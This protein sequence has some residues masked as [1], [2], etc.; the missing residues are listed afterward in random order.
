MISTLRIPLKGR[1][2][3][4]RKLRTERQWE[5]AF[6]QLIDRSEE[7]QNA[8]GCDVEVMVVVAHLLVDDF[9]IFSFRDEPAGR[10]VKVTLH[11]EYETEAGG[12]IQ[13]LEAF[14]G[15]T[16]SGTEAGTRLFPLRQLKAILPKA[17][18]LV[19][20]LEFEEVEPTKG[21][22]RFLPRGKHWMRAAK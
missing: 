10:P 20:K 14:E 18:H 11:I 17:N 21:F 16:L 6:H 7:A 22:R 5:E 13:M 3:S 9:V 15:K 1:R 2:Y 12:P 19:L 4:W 8:E